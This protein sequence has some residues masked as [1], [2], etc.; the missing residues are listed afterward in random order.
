MDLIVKGNPNDNPQL[1]H[2]DEDRIGSRVGKLP[3]DV[4]HRI[5]A[6][7]AFDWVMETN[8]GLTKFIK[9]NPQ[10]DL[11]YADSV[12]LRSKYT[13]LNSDGSLWNLVT[14]LPISTSR[15]RY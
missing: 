5:N 12:N 1:N 13:V 11:R 14:M 10:F 6:I 2:S 4:I 3:A 7:E 8:D 15:N 9:L